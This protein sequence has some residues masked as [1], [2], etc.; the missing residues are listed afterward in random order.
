[1]TSLQTKYDQALQS[2]ADEI[3]RL[4]EESTRISAQHELALK[5]CEAD[6]AK[7]SQAVV[8]AKGMQE[9]LEKKV[10]L[11]EDE[12]KKINDVLISKENEKEKQLSGQISELEKRLADSAAK[13]Q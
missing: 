5:K 3:N 4:R 12:K 13:V 9:Y 6:S 10:Q 1:M 7:N 11:C 2:H 8:D